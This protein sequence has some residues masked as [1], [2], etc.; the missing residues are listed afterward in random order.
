MRTAG[1]WIVRALAVCTMVALACS[2]SKEERLP[3]KE[4]AR[5]DIGPAGGTL[6]GGAV[7]IEIPAGALTAT[8]TIIINEDPNPRALP[9]ETQAAGALYVLQPDDVTFTIPVTVTLAIDPSKNPASSQGA[10]MLFRGEEG[11]AWTPYGVDESTAKVIVGKTTHF[12]PW[13]AAQAAETYCYLNQCAGF[14]RLDPNATAEEK[15]KSAG[16]LPGLDCRVPNTPGTTLGVECVGLAPDKG[17]PYDCHCIGSSRS[18]GPKGLPWERLPPDT[19]ITAM[20]RQCGAPACAPKPTF[21]CNLGVICGDSP[22]GGWN[23]GTAREPR[24]LCN[25]GAGGASCSCVTGQ[26]F[27]LPNTNKLTNDELVP[28]FQASCGGSC[29]NAGDD[30]ALDYVCPGTIQSTDPSGLCFVETAGTCRDNHVYRVECTKS[31]AEVGTCTCKVDGV[32]TKTVS[33]VCSD[34]YFACGFPKQQGDVASN[35]KCPLLVQSPLT[36]GPGGPK[37]CLNKTGGVCLDGHAYSVE[38]AGFP[39]E[40][41]EC[42]CKVDGVTS[43]TLTT[44]TCNSAPAACGFPPSK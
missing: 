9:D 11:N 12:S 2:A 13:S 10:V 16:L 17:P 5:R 31:G 36:E 44:E 14:S 43:K 8:K 35:R 4:I 42:T 26:T 6:V 3:L 37:G 28:A 29:V 39:D 30:P 22:N 1:G 15:S 21:A 40:I 38:C 32:A 7:T 41:S 33:S 34:S 23:C 18:L 24:I 27:K 20:A 19:A 25:G